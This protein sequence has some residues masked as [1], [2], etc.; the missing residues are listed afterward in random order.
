MS[1]NLVVCESIS[2]LAADK[3]QCITGRLSKLTTVLVSGNWKRRSKIDYS[4]NIETAIEITAAP[5]LNPKPLALD[6]LVGARPPPTE[7]PS[8][9]ILD[10]TNDG[11]PDG[12]SD[13]I[14][15]GRV[16]EATGALPPPIP[17]CAGTTGAATG[18]VVPALIT[19]A[20]TGA[21]E[22]VT[23]GGVIDGAAGGAVTVVGMS[24]VM[25]R[26]RD[27]PQ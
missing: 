20:A 18:A 13:G 9:G 10:G 25:V 16:D 11:I 7:G 19:G 23:G 12:A 4:K 1:N 15:E 17:P 21:A 22:T 27:S 6:A 8:D 3:E 14:T 2:T 24:P 26:V 5:A